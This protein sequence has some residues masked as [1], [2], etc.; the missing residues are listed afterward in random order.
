MHGDSL[1]LGGIGNSVFPA[2]PLV[3]EDKINIDGEV[4][5]A[6]WKAILAKCPGYFASQYRKSRHKI[7]KPMDFSSAVFNRICGTRR[8]LEKGDGSGVMQLI[9]DIQKFGG[10]VIPI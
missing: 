4:Y 3:V 10:S 8:L 2:K 6:S 1:S 5:G 7:L 9:A